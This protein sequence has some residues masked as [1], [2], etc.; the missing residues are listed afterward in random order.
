VLLDY[1]KKNGMQEEKKRA[2]EF[3]KNNKDYLLK[4]FTDIQNKTIIDDIHLIKK[5][6]DSVPV[7]GVAFGGLRVLNSFLCISSKIAK[8]LLK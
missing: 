1:T 8:F 7:P 5:F 4:K 3:I 6:S 2:D